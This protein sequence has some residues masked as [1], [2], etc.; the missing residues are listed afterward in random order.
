MQLLVQ[1][2]RVQLLLRELREL[3]AAAVAAVGAAAGAEGAEG[4]D[5]AQGLLK[6][7]LQREEPADGS[8][9]VGPRIVFVEKAKDTWI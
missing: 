7:L 9:Q 4:A 5:A 8:K 2:H 6:G 3:H 1:R